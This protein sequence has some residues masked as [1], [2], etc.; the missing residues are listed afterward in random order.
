MNFFRFMQHLFC[1][2]ARKVYRDAINYIDRQFIQGG[3][4]KITTFL[5][6]VKFTAHI[7]HFWT[8]RGKLDAAS[9]DQISFGCL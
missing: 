3:G 1:Q 2:V 4:R 9:Q 6:F 8:S 7:M 5:T